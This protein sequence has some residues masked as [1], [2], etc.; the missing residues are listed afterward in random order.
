MPQSLALGPVLLHISIDDLDG[1]NA[2]YIYR[3]H[4]SGWECQY[5]IRQQYI[6]E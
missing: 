1:K 6:S 4:K 5:L 3:L 2:Y